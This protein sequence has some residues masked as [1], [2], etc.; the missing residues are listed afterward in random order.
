MLYQVNPL[1]VGVAPFGILPRAGDLLFAVK[2]LLFF[3]EELM[4]V[5]DKADSY[6]DCGSQ[7]SCKKDDFQEVH[8]DAYRFHNN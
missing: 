4:N 2:H 3:P 1:M 5:F 6:H 8:P 7:N